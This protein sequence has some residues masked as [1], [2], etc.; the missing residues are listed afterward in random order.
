MRYDILSKCFLEIETRDEIN[1]LISNGGILPWRLIRKCT[2]LYS[3]IDL[4]NRSMVI[5]SGIKVTSRCSVSPLFQ[6]EI[7][8][9]GIAAK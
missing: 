7:I 1:K 9:S 6:R 3:Q 5:N 2:E 4:L 8:S